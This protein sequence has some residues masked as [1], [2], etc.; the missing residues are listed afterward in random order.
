MPRLDR[1]GA[2]YQRKQ[3]GF[4]RAVRTNQPNQATRRQIE[5][6]GIERAGLAITQ[7]YIRQAGDRGQ[8]AR[9]DHGRT[10]QGG[11]QVRGHCGNLIC[12]SRGQSTR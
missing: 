9:I 8:S 5:V 7:R 12:N 4:A 11:M 6:N 1:A 10:G 3:A 2:G